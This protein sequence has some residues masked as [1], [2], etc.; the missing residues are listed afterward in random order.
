MTE[1]LGF[2][3]QQLD[4]KIH[5]F[6]FGHNRTKLVELRKQSQKKIDLTHISYEKEFEN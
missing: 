2:P 6:S 1:G 5:A 4:S 3:R